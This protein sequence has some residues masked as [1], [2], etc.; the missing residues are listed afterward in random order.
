MRSEKRGSTAGRCFLQ[1]VPSTRHA[2]CYCP[3]VHDL[4]SHE[5]PSSQEASAGRGFFETYL[6]VTDVEVHQFLLSCRSGIDLTT[7][8]LIQGSG[9]ECELWKSPGLNR[10]TP[11]SNPDLFQSAMQQ[12]FNV[13]QSPGL[14]YETTPRPT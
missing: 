9:G 14:A 4:R 5:Q 8:Q 3:G 11:M 10:L 6:V 13:S 12:L 7:L 2:R 1:F